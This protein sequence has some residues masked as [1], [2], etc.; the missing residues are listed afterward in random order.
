[1]HSGKTTIAN[2]LV[3]HHGFHR[4]SF[5]AE[6]KNDLLECGF[7]QE[8]IDNKPPWMRRLMIAYGQA[9]RAVDPNYW[10]SRVQDVLMEEYGNVVIDDMRFKNEYEMLRELGKLDE[11]DVKLMRVTR[12]GYEREHLEG[13][14]DESETGLDGFFPWD[15]TVQSTSGDVRGLIQQAERE[16]GLPHR[17]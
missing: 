2:H 15:A 16:L 8:D 13:W 3:E 7:E 12:L 10:S 9:R 1:M 6:L 4:V 5:A 11:I 17:G 14:N